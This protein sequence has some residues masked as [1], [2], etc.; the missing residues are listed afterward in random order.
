MADQTIANTP[1]AGHVTLPD[2]RV[3]P[4]LDTW[5]NQ[6]ANNPQGFQ[7]QDQRT[8]IGQGYSKAVAGPLTDALGN[9]IS[10]RPV[11][12]IAERTG[13]L[14]PETSQTIGQVGNAIASGIVPQTLTQ[15]GIDAGLM[16]GGGVGG[17]MKLG[18]G[19]TAATSALGAVAGG[20]GGGYADTGTA[21]GALTGAGQGLVQSV[22]AAAAGEVWNYARKVG[23]ERQARIVQ[24]VDAEKTAAT[25]PQMKRLRGVFN[26]PTDEASLEDLAKG[27]V[28]LKMPDG[29]ERTWNKG[30]KALGDFMDQQDQLVQ[31]ALDKAK[32]Q[33][34]RSYMFPTEMEQVEGKWVPTKWGPWDESRAVMSELRQ[35]GYGGM[36]SNPLA[37]TVSGRDQKQ[38]L[39]EMNRVVQSQ[40]H[41]ADGSGAALKAFLDGQETYK[42][43]EYFLKTVREGFKKK[44]GDR[45]A[46]NSD[47]VAN[48]LIDERV[49]AM[50]A[51]GQEDYWAF[52]NANRVTPETMGMVDVWQPQGAIANIAQGV[53]LPGAGY[54][55]AHLTAPTMVGQPRDL[56]R[57][58][59]QGVALG[60]TQALSAPMQYLADQVRQPQ[61]IPGLSGR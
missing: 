13:L 25:L 4:T 6:Q 32:Q 37:P 8:Q 10:N 44:T 55:R 21:Q 39:A 24:G 31:G 38:A 5:F 33:Y 52:A 30:Q 17:A 50:R 40:L 19:L 57:A 27:T 60:G 14:S 48:K 34:G 23:P 28:T 49:K 47:M 46:Y 58:A 51:L 53:N 56:S 15:A 61:G 59:T 12:E 29:T 22:P 26:G 1:A 42:A 7:A 18:R 16:A 35:G 9:F 36:K 2:G 41:L 54:V 45:V 43:G 11:R 20:F 3:V